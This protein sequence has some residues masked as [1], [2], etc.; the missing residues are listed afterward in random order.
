MPAD[1]LLRIPE[2][3]ARFTIAAEKPGVV[4]FDFIASNRGD[5]WLFN[6]KPE[7]SADFAE[8]GATTRELAKD[9]MSSLKVGLGPETAAAHLVLRVDTR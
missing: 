3:H 1:L 2:P 6:R 4:L 8:L 9:I 5:S 7:G